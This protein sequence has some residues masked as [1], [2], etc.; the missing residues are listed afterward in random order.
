MVVIRIENGFIVDK[1]VAEVWSLFTDIEKIAMCIPTCAEAT[2]NGDEACLLLI[3]MK[4]GLIT[5]E[6]KAHL[7]ITDIDHHQQIRYEGESIPS[8]AFAKAIKLGNKPTKAVYSLVVDFDAQEEFKTKVHCSLNLD[9]KG[10]LRRV[11]KSVINVQRKTLEGGFI[12]NMSNT[13]GGNIELLDEE[14]VLEE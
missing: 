9:A 11:Y 5:V 10:K 4:L 3:K 1:S 6:N 8:D 12:E 7:E 2:L 13:L 14:S